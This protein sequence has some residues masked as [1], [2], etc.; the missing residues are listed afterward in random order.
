MKKGRSFKN[1]LPDTLLKVAYE[2]IAAILPIFTEIAQNLKRF[3][4]P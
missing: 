2:G 4:H 1:N 3:R